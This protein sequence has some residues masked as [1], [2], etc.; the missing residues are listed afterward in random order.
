MHDLEIPVPSE[1][2]DLVDMDLFW[3]QLEYSAITRGL[4]KGA[5]KYNVGKVHSCGTENL[6]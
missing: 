5:Y 1:E 3:E 4:L 6:T 2:T